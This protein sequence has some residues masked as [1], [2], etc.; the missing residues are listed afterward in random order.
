MTTRQHTLQTHTLQAHAL[1][2]H[3]LQTYTRLMLHAH[4]HPDRTLAS[5]CH[6]CCQCAAG[7]QRGTLCS[8]KQILP[9]RGI[10]R[11][12]HT[13]IHKSHTHMNMHALQ[14]EHTRLCMHTYMS[15]PCR[16]RGLDWAEE[17]AALFS[18]YKEQAA[19]EG[20]EGRLRYRCL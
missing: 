3:A 19:E 7:L 8:K 11:H 2:T 6:N 16:S 14:D 15:I 17:V 10:A 4:L 9:M 5:F 13:C 20:Q 18:S 1:Q 12:R